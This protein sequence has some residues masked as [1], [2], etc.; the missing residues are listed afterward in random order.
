MRQ[1]CSRL[2]PRRG[3]GLTATGR[4]NFQWHGL[5]LRRRAELDV[6]QI[7]VNQMSIRLRLFTTRHRDTEIHIG[8]KDITSAPSVLSVLCVISQLSRNSLKCVGYS[9]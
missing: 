8:L 9:I 4:T 7:A 6:N 1:D 5:R 3:R 2:Y